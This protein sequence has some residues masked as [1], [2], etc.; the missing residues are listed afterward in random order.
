MIRFSLSPAHDQSQLD[1]LAAA[2][3]VLSKKARQ[4]KEH[5]QKK[6]GAKL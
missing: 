1:K 3:D 6:V 4:I 5:S 2:F